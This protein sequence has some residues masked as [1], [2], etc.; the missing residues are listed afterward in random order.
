MVLLMVFYCDKES[1]H[2]E[3]LETERHQKKSLENRINCKTVL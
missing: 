3:A 2:Q 1:G